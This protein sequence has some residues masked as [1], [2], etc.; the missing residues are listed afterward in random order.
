MLCPQGYIHNRSWEFELNIHLCS[1]QLKTVGH[2]AEP[3]G[4]QSRMGVCPGASLGTTDGSL[5][6]LRR[7][8][9]HLKVS[10][11]QLLSSRNHCW[12]GDA[13]PGPTWSI[14][15][16]HAL[17]CS[18]PKSFLLREWERPVTRVFSAFC[19]WERARRMCV[20]C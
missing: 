15:K 6:K 19:G 5:L 9:G 12:P 20:G 11:L 16:G 14:Q 17:T 7:A 18:S 3:V 10:T 1:G 2:G 8:V 13:L 4:P